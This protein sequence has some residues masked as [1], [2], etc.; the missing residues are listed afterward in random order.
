M[1]RLSS[2]ILAGLALLLLLLAVDVVIGVGEQGGETSS[3]SIVN[4]DESLTSAVVFE[5]PTTDDDPS[6]VSVLMAS[7]VSRGSV[8]CGGV[9]SIEQAA[10][11]PKIKVTN[12]NNGDGEDDSN[13][14]DSNVIDP[15]GLYT[16]LLV[17]TTALGGALGIFDGKAQQSFVHPIL[18]YGAVNIEGSALIAGLSLDLQGG[19]DDGS[20]SGNNRLLDVFS[21]YRGPNPPQP[22]DPW[23]IPHIEETLFVYEYMLGLQQ[24]QSSSGD[25]N[26]TSTSTTTNSLLVDVP[27]DIENTRFDYE[28]FFDE[29]GADFDNIIS[30]YFVS[31]WCVEEVEERTRTTHTP[32]TSPPLQPIKSLPIQITT[33]SP[34]PIS[35][36]LSSSSSSSSTPDPGFAINNSTN[37]DMKKES[38]EIVDNKNSNNERSPLYSSSDNTNTAVDVDVD[39]TTSSS[40]PGATTTT[41]GTNAFSFSVVTTILSTVVGVALLF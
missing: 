3:T 23:A 12:Y 2:S 14:N 26:G 29:V 39:D 34:P 22:S 18:H 41:N 5:C 35:E 11:A 31:G 1:R 13:N 21:S 9:L 37:D 33:S 7:Y 36:T 28:S 20:G 4:C 6:T 19:G 32:T 27:I 40:P 25:N 38:F 10:I 24:Q 8:D 16:L 15:N 30:T 17:D